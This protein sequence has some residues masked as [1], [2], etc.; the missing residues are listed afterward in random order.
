[1]FMSSQDTQKHISSGNVARNCDSHES[2]KDPVV[3]EEKS[4]YKC[5]DGGKVFSKKRLLA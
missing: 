3:Q 5:R 2:D 4:V 1:M